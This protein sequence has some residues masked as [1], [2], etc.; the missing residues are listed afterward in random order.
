MEYDVYFL[1]GVTAAEIL[2]A[3]SIL[4][5]YIYTNRKGDAHKIKP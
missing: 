2:F 1:M 5:L 4:G 3:I